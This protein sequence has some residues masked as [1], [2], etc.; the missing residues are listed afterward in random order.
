MLPLQSRSEAE[1]LKGIVDLYI[2]LK[3]EGFHVRQLHIDRTAEFRSKVLTEWCRDRCM[4]SDVHSN[5]SAP[6]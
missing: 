1:I 4:G 5:R 2:R 6:E 3:L